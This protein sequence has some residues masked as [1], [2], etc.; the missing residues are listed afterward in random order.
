MRHIRICDVGCCLHLAKC[1]SLPGNCTPSAVAAM[2]AASLATGTLLTTAPQRLLTISVRCLL[3]TTSAAVVAAC[4]TIDGK[5]FAVG[6]NK[7]KC[8]ELFNVYGPPT[9]QQGLS[10][11][12][13]MHAAPWGIGMCPDTLH[14]LVQYWK[15]AGYTFVTV[16][17][18]CCVVQISTSEDQQT[19][20]SPQ[21][22]QLCSRAIAV[23][24]CLLLHLLTE[25]AVG[26]LQSCLFCAAGGWHCAR[27]IRHAASCSCGKSSTV[28]SECESL[29]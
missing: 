24:A 26:C 11:V 14:R 19:Y 13:L 3:P 15:E 25:P 21:V 2:H 20:T 22:Q 17:A 28:P 23:A 10:G 12:V 7:D 29:V 9:V 27:N 16:R 6:G 8:G 1:F 4:R 5:D 18:A